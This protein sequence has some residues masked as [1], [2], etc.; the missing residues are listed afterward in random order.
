MPEIG[1]R[2]S[3]LSTFGDDA[4]VQTTGEQGK[5]ASPGTQE[6]SNSPSALWARFKTFVN[7][8]ASEQGRN[9]VAAYHLEKQIGA[10][11]GEGAAKM[12]KSA[13][14]NQRV[15]GKPLTAGRI[16]IILK[17][18]QKAQAK[19]LK[20]M[21]LTPQEIS[22]AQQNKLTMAEC[23][24]YK[25]ADIPI[26]ERTL[27]GEWRGGKVVSSKDLSGGGVS[28]PKMIGFQ[29]QSG[30]QEGVY[31]QSRGAKGLPEAQ[32]TMLGISAGKPQ[33]AARNIASKVMDD[34][35]GLDCLPRS[36][37]GS[38]KGELGIVQAKAEGVV[39]NE[40]EDSHELT[41]KE[42][43][44]A[45]AKLS[46]EGGKELLEEA[47]IRVEPGAPPRFFKQERVR[48]EI[49]D[50]DVQ[51][52]LVGLQLTDFL[53][54]QLDRHSGNYFIKPRGED[55]PA[56]VTGIDNDISFGT[57]PTDARRPEG[58]LLPLPPVIDRNMAD[59]VDALSEKQIRDDLQGIL[60]EREIDATVAR[61]RQMQE[62]VTALRAKP[63]G[64]I[65][66]SQWGTP[67]VTDALCPKAGR[68]ITYLG[69]LNGELGRLPAPPPRT[70]ATPPLMRSPTMV[71]DQPPT[72]VT[73]SADGIVV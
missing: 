61:M 43:E 51:R 56:K 13:L 53:C 23:R 9:R 2:F 27:V 31:K 35:L 65:E 4:R 64:V 17:D 46:R 10:E 15:E 5:L 69:V 59:K 40:R 70:P 14:Y 24:M 48:Q 54:G 29:T 18:A 37:I 42:A 28:A 67:T 19:E 71:F 60:P 1:G 25:R 12:A 11:Y 68:Q 73:P 55:G 62:H 16:R 6:R 63:G 34:A 32:A 3:N 30:V 36:E 49:N 38:V 66:R 45:L 39:G 20:A 41:G 8:P 50:P 7:R 33:L 44:K 26:H 57:N 47:F 58:Q 52:G 72:P 21:G 22:V